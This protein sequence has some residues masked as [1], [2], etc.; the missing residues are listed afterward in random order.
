MLKKLPL[1]LAYSATV[2]VSVILFGVALSQRVRTG[3]PRD[4]VRRLKQR[5]LAARGVSAATAS[6]EADLT[7]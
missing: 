2:V 6:R 3:R 1:P 7:G 5:T 4:P